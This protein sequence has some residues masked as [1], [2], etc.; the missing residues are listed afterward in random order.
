MSA[1]VKSK[2][3]SWHESEI[4]SADNQ[5]DM[6]EREGRERRFE[7]QSLAAEHVIQNGT[8]KGVPLAN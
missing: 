8:R 7:S 3:G 2:S 6:R 1:G 4:Y 5:D